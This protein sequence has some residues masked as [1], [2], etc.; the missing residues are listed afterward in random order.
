METF[1]QSR[2]VVMLDGDGSSREPLLEGAGDGV[3]GHECVVYDAGLLLAD[4]VHS[5]QPRPP[6]EAG[7]L[8]LRQEGEAALALEPPALRVQLALVLV[9]HPVLTSRARRVSGGG[10]NI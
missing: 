2:K 8:L 3:D 6:R 9:P 7:G 4:P 5:V 10:K 1:L